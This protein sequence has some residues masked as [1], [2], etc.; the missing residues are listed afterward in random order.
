MNS[1]MTLTVFNLHQK[2]PKGVTIKIQVK[3]Y[4]RYTR[5]KIVSDTPQRDK[6]A[7]DMQDRRSIPG[8]TMTLHTY[9]PRLM[10]L[11]NIN[12]LHLMVS[13]IYPK[14]GIIGQRQYSKVKGQ[15]KITP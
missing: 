2:T 8:H 1:N 14:Q 12:F 3:R 6:I 13:E 5:D 7:S 11:P 10:S 4:N 15:I 9:N